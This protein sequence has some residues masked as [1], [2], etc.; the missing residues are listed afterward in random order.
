MTKED[1]EI[2]YDRV[3]TGD[4]LSRFL[5][6]GVAASLAPMARDAAFPLDLQLRKD[7][8]TGR[9]WA[10]VYA[11]LTAVLNVE[12]RSQGFRLTAH[13]TWSRKPKYGFRQRWRFDLSKDELASEWTDVELYLE[14]VIPAATKSHGVT[15]GAVQ[16]AVSKS[17]DK[18]WVM[19]DRE[20]VTS[21]R[22]QAT[23]KRI[24]TRC[25]EPIV[26][27]LP[28]DIPGAT[29]TKFGPECDLLALRPDTGQLVAV[30]VK[31]YDGA[32][33]AWVAA[34]A[35]MYARLLNE[36]I[37]ADERAEDI[38]RGTV[39]Q[40][41][42]LGLFD[43]PFKVDLSLPVAPVVALQR[44]A[45]QKQTERMIAVRAALPYTA[46]GVPRVEIFEVSITG[47]LTPLARRD[48]QPC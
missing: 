21:F 23:K 3:V 42:K 40:R 27:A 1:F 30:E 35:T 15:E 18:S 12:E 34:Q 19:L 6:G 14:R 24:L 8:K 43:G 10:T 9:Q 25:Y 4:F 22:D 11:G 26:A 5:P 2:R 41:Q 17:R 16:A 31:P 20:V 46:L 37:A 33:I 28:S 48:D 45:G 32:G 47:D 44:G 38:V 13:D 39:Q 36:W 7:T 29:P